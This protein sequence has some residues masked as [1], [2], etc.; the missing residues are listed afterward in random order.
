MVLALVSDLF[1]GARIAATAKLVGTEAATYRHTEALLARLPRASGLLVD[2]QVEHGS[3]L[4][5]VR[6]ARAQRSDLPIIAFLPHVEV[7][8]ARA[9]STAGADQVLTRQEFST[10]LPEILRDLASAPRGATG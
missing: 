8:L 6:L 3:P 4:L 9:T 2:M 5:L 7:E 10:R 1:F